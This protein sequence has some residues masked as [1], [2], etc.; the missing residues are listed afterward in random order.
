MVHCHHAS[1]VNRYEDMGASKIMGSK[2]GREK[3]ER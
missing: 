3:G 1:I 2:K